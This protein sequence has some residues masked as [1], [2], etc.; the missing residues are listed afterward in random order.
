MGYKQEAILTEKSHNSQL[1]NCRAPE[2]TLPATLWY[3]Y[4]D[5][6][7]I[8]NYVISQWVWVL[9][10]LFN[11]MVCECCLL[12]QEVMQ[13]ELLPECNLLAPSRVG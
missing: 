4:R 12:Y 9:A 8:G 3:L 11:A 10:I 2:T 5:V 6:C 1:S 13:L 7:L